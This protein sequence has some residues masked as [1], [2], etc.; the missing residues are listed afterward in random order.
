MKNKQNIND[1]DR[2]GVVDG[3]FRGNQANPNNNLNLSCVGDKLNDDNCLT[4]D[5]QV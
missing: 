3:L 4:A 5:L 1:G 2:I